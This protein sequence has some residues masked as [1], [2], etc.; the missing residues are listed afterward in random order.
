MVTPPVCKSLALKQAIKYNITKAKPAFNRKKPPAEPS[1]LGDRQ[2][3]EEGKG[4]SGLDGGLNQSAKSL[5]S[6]NAV[7]TLFHH[8][9]KHSYLYRQ[10]SVSNYVIS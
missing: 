1:N 9:F 7:I 4:E 10:R 8:D 6:T 5:T 2:I 3:M